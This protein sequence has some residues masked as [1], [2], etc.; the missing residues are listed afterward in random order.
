MATRS[1][2]YAKFRAVTGEFLW[3]A[4]YERILEN[5]CDIAHAPFVHGGAF[6]NPQKPEVPAYELEMPDEWSAF[7]T[8]S[9]GD[10][11]GGLFK[12]AVY[13]ALIAGA[14]CL[15]GLQA[16]S[17]ATAVGRAATTAVVTSLV[18]IITA[19]GVFA[20]LFY[21]LGI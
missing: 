20:V 11:I 18:A 17:S 5:G 19:C 16:G 7:A 4:N 3:K 21:V 15:R 10:T 9:L 1:I 2:A 13:G 14:G 12:S 6:G 8:V